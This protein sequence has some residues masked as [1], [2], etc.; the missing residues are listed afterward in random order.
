[1]RRISW[2]TGHWSHD[3]RTETVDRV[4]TTGVQ[5]RLAFHYSLCLGFWLCLTKA[6]STMHIRY[7]T[8]HQ[9]LSGH[10]VEPSGD[11]YGYTPAASDSLPGGPVLW[12]CGRCLSIA[13]GPRIGHLWMHPGLCNYSYS[14][15]A[16]AN[17]FPYSTAFR[18]LRR[19]SFFL[20]FRNHGWWTFWSFRNSTG[21]ALQLRTS[22]FKICSWDGWFTRCGQYIH[23]LHCLFCYFWLAVSTYVRVLDLWLIN[24][25]TWCYCYA[26]LLLFSYSL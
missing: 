9:G 21:K 23:V 1:M 12:L 14:D 20:M 10:E 13:W 22:S 8:C 26:V 7:W 17:S 25:W 3:M 18:Y 4:Y 15:V 24:Y 5:G 19:S 16:V 11:T 2:R 6:R